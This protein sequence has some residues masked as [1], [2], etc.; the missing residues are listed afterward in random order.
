VTPKQE[1]AESFCASTF[2]ALDP[3]VVM[4]LLHTR[5]IL[6]ASD[7]TRSLLIAQCLQ[8]WG[9]RHFGAATPVRAHNPFVTQR[10]LRVTQRALSVTQRALRDTQRALRDT[11]RAL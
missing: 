4:E 9:L 3:L 6:A 10:A 1:G 8:P 2:A 11:H 5:E 7:A